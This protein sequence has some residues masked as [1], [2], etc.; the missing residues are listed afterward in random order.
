[1]KGNERLKLA[2]SFFIELV[3]PALAEEVEGPSKPKTP[4]DVG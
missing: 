3:E 1:M 4:T 2:C